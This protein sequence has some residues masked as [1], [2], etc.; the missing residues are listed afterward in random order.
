MQNHSAF[1]SALKIESSAASKM[2]SLQARHGLKN[3]CL[4]RCGLQ[5]GRN[6]SLKK[7]FSQKLGAE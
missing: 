6:T 2:E 7:W 4:K 5:P 1:V 3:H